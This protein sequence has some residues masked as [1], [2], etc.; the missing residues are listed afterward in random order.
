MG[1][2]LECASPLAQWGAKFTSRRAVA[3]GCDGT[4]RLGAAALQNEAYAP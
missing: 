3:E 4:K 2:D 1:M